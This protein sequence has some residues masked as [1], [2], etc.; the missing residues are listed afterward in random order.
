MQ[1]RGLFF[2]IG[3]G[4]FCIHERERLE[5][6]P[7]FFSSFFLSSSFLIFAKTLS[8]IHCFVHIPPLFFT[9]DLRK[10]SLLFGRSK[11][12]RIQQ[13]APIYA[14]FNESKRIGQ[15]QKYWQISR[16][17]LNS[18]T[19]TQL[20]LKILLKC[21]HIWGKLLKKNC[22]EDRVFNTN[23]AVYRGLVKYKNL[24]QPQTV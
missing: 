16:N 14:F 10:T 9:F 13:V 8:I 17:L 4:S 15:A 12:F 24:S 2:I 21:E 5:K 18:K 22:I 1:K 6:G 7:W 20:I 11:I 19:L 23:N 3:E